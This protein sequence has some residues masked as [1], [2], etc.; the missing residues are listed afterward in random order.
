MLRYRDKA[1]FS[2][3]PLR[4]L[5]TSTGSAQTATT[6]SETNALCEKT[7]TGRV[8]KRGLQLC[9]REPLGLG[10]LLDHRYHGRRDRHVVYAGVSSEV[11]TRDGKVEGI[12]YRPNFTLP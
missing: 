12:V 6:V 4:L 9:L 10:E 2:G 3:L 1:R 7:A 5:S 8:T 11:T